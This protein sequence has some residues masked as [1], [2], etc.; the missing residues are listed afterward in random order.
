MAAGVH[1]KKG[2]REKEK[3]GSKRKFI[4]GGKRK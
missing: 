3:E 4:N 1:N 2:R